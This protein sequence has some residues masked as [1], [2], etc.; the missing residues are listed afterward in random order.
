MIDFKAMGKPRSRTIAVAYVLLISLISGAWLIHRGASSGARARVNGARLFDEVFTLV[1]R[2]YVDSLPSSALYRRAVDGMLYELGD[3][4]TAFLPPDKLG[5]L[6]E[7]S[8]GNYAGL[9]L[10]VDVRDG[11][12]VV[13]TPLPSSPAER[14]G[15]LTG[16]R[17]VEAAGKSTQ[18]WTLTDVGV[19]F[20][21]R[22]G[23]TITLRIERPG[24]AQ[25]F[26]LTLVRGAI[27]YSAVRR[28]ALLAPGVGYVDLKAFSDSTTEELSRAIE[29]LR[30]Q[31]MKSLVLDLRANPGGLLAQGVQVSDLFLESGQK[32]VSM[33]GR[34]PQ[35]NA[36]FIDRAPQKWASVP[37][38]VLVDNRS[39]SAAEI[40][41]GALQ[42]HDRA[43]VVGRPT[44]GKGSAQSVYPL[45]ESGGLKLTTARWFT[46]SGR[47]INRW[48][49]RENEDGFADAD[50]DD[51]K[52]FR[53]DAGR[54]VLGGG[55]ITPDVEVNDSVRVAEISELQTAPGKHVGKF[56]D[57]MTR[58]ALSIK[59]AGTLRDPAFT[60][61]AEM[62]EELWK[63]MA[64]SGVDVPKSIYDDASNA[65]SLLLG[66]DI[67]RYVFGP[68]AE[69]R[70]RAATDEALAAAIRISVDAGSTKALLER[71]EVER[72]RVSK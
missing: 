9:G 34:I 23:E 40:V 22:P 41:A 28:T 70:R 63:R 27:H 43:A 71:A 69:F 62:R 44:F 4:Y 35:S 13:I 52:K 11:A 57:V 51:T 66:Y 64:A 8:T 14:A 29:L 48:V 50:A 18:G 54:T 65:V 15:I 45:G 31:G 12:V 60:V 37:L 58:Y 1:T 42:D 17:I 61:S 2:S 67:A 24:V 55:G 3:P 20:R 46:P 30:A 25:G 53:T 36:E 49:K 21:G 68:E 7:S 56:R 10:Q 5:R 16:D 33:K 26:P 38:V 72:K 19:V 32:I 6:S 59:A 39:A 47:S